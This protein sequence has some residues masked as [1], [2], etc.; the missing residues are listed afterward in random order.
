MTTR[1][2]RTVA[3]P[4][5]IDDLPAIPSSWSVVDDADLRI[6]E[7][8]AWTHDRAGL[9]VTVEHQRRPTQM[10]TPETSVDDTG[11]VTKVHGAD[12]EQITFDLSGKLHAYTRAHELMLTFPDGDFE[13]V[14][15]DIPW[16]GPRDPS[17]WE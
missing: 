4:S 7:N 9:K 17:E 13:P 15:R 8:C 10:H 12:V 1:E 5:T 14:W 2:V 3:T 11:F 6:S 16:E